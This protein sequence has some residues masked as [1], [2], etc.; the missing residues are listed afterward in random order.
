M[1]FIIISCHITIHFFEFA[2]FFSVHSSF[3]HRGLLLLEE[4]R[5]TRVL[6]PGAAGNGK[7]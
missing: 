7:F 4:E 5:K 2:L 6:P 1:L 3:L